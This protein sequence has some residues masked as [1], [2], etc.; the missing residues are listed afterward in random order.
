M[1]AEAGSHPRVNKYQY[2]EVSADTEMPEYMDA[3]AS[4]LPK[5]PEYH[6]VPVAG[7]RYKVNI[8]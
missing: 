1:D 2:A 8:Q 4:L 3:D 7:A 5:L 6:E